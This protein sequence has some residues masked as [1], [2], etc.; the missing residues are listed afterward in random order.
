MGSP[1][2]VR[3]FILAYRIAAKVIENKSVNTFL[4]QQDFHSGIH[5]VKKKTNVLN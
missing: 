1:E 5:Q 4:Q 2:V 3:G